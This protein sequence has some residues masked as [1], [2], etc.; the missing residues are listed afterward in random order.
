VAAAM[1]APW[2]VLLHGLGVFWERRRRQN[3]EG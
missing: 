1:G 2:L 3:R